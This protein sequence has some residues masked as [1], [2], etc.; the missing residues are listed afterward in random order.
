MEKISTVGEPDF[1]ANPVGGY[2]SED[3]EENIEDLEFEGV[4]FV[5]YIQSYIK[6][7]HTYET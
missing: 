5:E 3:Q 1:F 4:P 2:S 6:I 7:H